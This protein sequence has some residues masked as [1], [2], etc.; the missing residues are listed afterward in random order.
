MKRNWT[1]KMLWFVLG[2]VGSAI[3]TMIPRA[4]SAP[5]QGLQEQINE[6]KVRVSQLEHRNAAA[7]EAAEEM[8]KNSWRHPNPQ[9]DSR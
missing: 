2:M 6:L 8:R 4:H 9:A 3:L 5:A 7:D 1:T